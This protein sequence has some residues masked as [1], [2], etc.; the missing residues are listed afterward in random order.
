MKKGRLHPLQDDGLAGGYWIAVGSYSQELEHNGFFLG[1]LDLRWFYLDN[2]LGL[3]SDLDRVS[4]GIWI[5]KTVRHRILKHTKKTE[6]KQN[7]VFTGRLD[8][9]VD[10]DLGF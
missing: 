2:W 4:L 10:L 1:R 7:L 5:L 9:L 8:L 6:Q 3:S